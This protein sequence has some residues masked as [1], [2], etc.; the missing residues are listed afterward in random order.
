MR[1]LGPTRGVYLEGY[2]AVFTAEVESDAVTRRSIRFD[3]PTTQAEIVK[4]QVQKQTRIEVLEEAN[5][6]IACSDGAGSRR[7]ARD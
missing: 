7:R 5:D 6:R 2:G 4:L 1:L 3:R